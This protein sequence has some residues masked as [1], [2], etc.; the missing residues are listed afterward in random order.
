MTSTI[1]VDLTLTAYNIDPLCSI[2]A[3][4]A[5]SDF[6]TTLPDNSWVDI[7]GGSGFNISTN[8]NSSYVNVKPNSV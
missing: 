6:D 3:T 8:T 2:L 5:N 4:V 1:D 7:V